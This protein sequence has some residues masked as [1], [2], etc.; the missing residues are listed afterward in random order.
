MSPQA[1][2]PRRWI[3]LILL[4][5]EA[6]LPPEKR[7]AGRELDQLLV[8]PSAAGDGGSDARRDQE[9]QRRDVVRAARNVEEEVAVL[10][11]ARALV[12]RGYEEDAAARANKPARADRALRA[13]S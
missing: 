12:R 3:A 6:C 7:P 13:P 11:A 10:H 2:D 4:C 1:L 8:C 9:P 5:E